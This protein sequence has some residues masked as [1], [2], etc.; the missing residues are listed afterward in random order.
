MSFNGSAQSEVD[1]Q[2]VEVSWRHFDQNNWGAMA[3]LEAQAMGHFACYD[4]WPNNSF[5]GRENGVVD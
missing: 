3:L 2:T 4:W 5:V 1:L